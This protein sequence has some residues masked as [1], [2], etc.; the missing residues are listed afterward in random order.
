MNG[1]IKITSPNL[2]AGGDFTG[3][4]NLGTND[5]TLGP[6]KT[7]EI[8][9]TDTAIN[10]VV[11]GITRVTVNNAGQMVLGNGTAAA[12]SLTFTGNTGTGILQSGTEV[13]VAVNGGDYFAFRSDGLL[14]NSSLT[15][16]IGFGASF[17]TNLRAAGAANPQWGVNSATPIA[18][19]HNLA[20]SVT[21]GGATTDTAG[22]NATIQPGDGVGTGGSGSIIFRTAPVATT[23]NAANT[24]AAAMTI[25]PTGIVTNKL[26]ATAAAAPTIA[27]ATTIAPTTAIAFVSGITTIQ[28]ITPPSPISL[29]GGQITLIPTGVFVTGLTGNI[30]LASTSVVSKALIMTYDVTTTK[31]YPSY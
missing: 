15:N 9:G 5:L 31:W 14:I 21:A 30:A 10:L 8:N 18:Y 6:S 29:G 20:P 16:G 27:S 24:M 7:T 22:A 12:P 11:G 28:T 3:D 1:G 26:V 19:Q 23:G 17:T 4:L 2:V 13:H 25:A